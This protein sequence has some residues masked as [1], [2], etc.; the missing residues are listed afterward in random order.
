MRKAFRSIGNSKVIGYIAIIF[1]IVIVPLTI[2]VFEL[3]DS[4]FYLSLG[5]YFYTHQVVPINPYNNTKPQTLFGPVYGLIFSPIESLSKPWGVALIPTIQFVF[6]F[7]SAVMVYKS[8]RPSYSKKWSLL[9]ATLFILLPFN[10]LYATF[11]L[12][13]TLTQFFMACY[14]FVLS[15]VFQ[16]KTSWATPSL[17]VLISGIMTLTRYAYVLL[18][19]VTIG[20]WVIWSIQ[21]LK[22]MRKKPVTIFL[23]APAIAGIGLIVIWM[24]F[25]YQINGAWLLS[26]FSGRHLYDNVIVQGHFL[27]AEN[28]KTLKPFLERVPREF[29]F[30]PWWYSQLMFND[31]IIPETTVDRMFAQVSYA[32]IL[33]QPIP[34]AFHVI[35]MAFL[36]P[37]TVPDYPQDMVTNLAACQNTACLQCVD[38]P[39]RSCWTKSLCEPAIKSCQ[40]QS[41]W[42]AWSTS[43][44]L[45]YPYVTTGLFLLGCFG[46]LIAFYRGNDFLKMVA[47]LFVLLHLFQSATEWLVGRFLIPLYPLYAVLLIASLFTIFNVVKRLSRY[48]LT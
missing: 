29:L 44:I 26:V 46:I 19:L 23:H 47:G 31:G 15:R 5:R 14:L 38:A 33:H 17:L 48:R 22:A 30:R 41:L 42:A 7:L 37:A 9:G 25:N 11:M 40:M 28:D 12:S 16:R 39:W 32:A 13:E 3:P 27:P 43:N 1:C 35:R 34:Y 24:Y 36:M 10:T 18:L 20:W 8:L 45:F 21:H 2:G 6:L 4:Y